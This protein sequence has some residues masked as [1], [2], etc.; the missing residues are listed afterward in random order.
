MNKLVIFGILLVVLVII[1][2]IIILVISK[3]KI[4][5]M[6]TPLN[7]AQEDI[8]NYLKQKYKLYKEITQFI[9]DNLSIKEDAFNNFF[10]FNS[11]ECTPEE[12][13]TLLDK[14][15]YEINEYV[16]NYDE[17]LKNK[18][19][20]KLKRELYDIELNLEATIEY[21]NNKLTLYDDLK[22]N[23]PTSFCTKF[24]EFDEYKP[25]KNDIKEITRLVNLN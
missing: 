17:L 21:Y 22:N 4:S 12:L 16:D 7:I 5:E 6:L 9:K 10:S 25:I 3:S 19:F 23:G 11:K 15:T 24:F 18:D 2:L 13:I 20:M 8:N 14:T 1:F